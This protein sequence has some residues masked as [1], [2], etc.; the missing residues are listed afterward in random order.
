MNDLLF[1]KYKVWSLEDFDV[2]PDEQPQDTY[3]F[4][5][6]LADF[7]AEG[8]M[9]IKASWSTDPRYLAEDVYEV[10]YSDP[11]DFDEL[12]QTL[13]VAGEPELTDDGWKLARTAQNKPQ[14]EAELCVRERR[15][16]LIAETDWW[17]GSDLVISQAQIDYRAA[18]R[19]V[20]QQDGFPYSVVWPVKP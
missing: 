11:D 12:T 7:R 9:P 8:T 5:Y 14:D 18:L 20:P 13:I 3:I 15:D 10:K 19:N 1:I 16:S 17:A 2:A 4:P 6:T